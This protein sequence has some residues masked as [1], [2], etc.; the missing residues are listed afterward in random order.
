MA[1]FASSPSSFIAGTKAKAAE[2]NAKI[3]NLYSAVASGTHDQYINGLHFNRTSN[4]T[5]GVTAGSCYF[6]AYHTIDSGTT[7]S[8]KSS[9]SRMAILGVL[10]VHGTLDITSGAVALVL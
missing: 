7:Y 8:L 1:S 10:T 5:V 9:T 2:I 3:S 6:N 4:G